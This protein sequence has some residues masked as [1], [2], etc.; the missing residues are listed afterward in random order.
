MVTDMFLLKQSTKKKIKKTAKEY[1]LSLVLA[2]GSKISG[3]A[4]KESDL[5]IGVLSK[6]AHFEKDYFGLYADLSKIFKGEDIDLVFINRADPLLL[7]KIAENCLLIYGSKR[8][9]S[10]FKVYALE[11]YYDFQK[12]FELE[13]KYVKGFIRGLKPVP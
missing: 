12:H 6:K 3:W 10:W 9:F 8:S 1:N 11:R 5:D 4:R 13:R 7:K 2:F